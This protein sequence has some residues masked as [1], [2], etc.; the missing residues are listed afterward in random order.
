MSI[1]STGS[2]NA[3]GS[4]STLRASASR[5]SF[6]VFTPGNTKWLR[7]CANNEQ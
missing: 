1:S 4:L 7:A 6:M 2:D 5:K 3:K